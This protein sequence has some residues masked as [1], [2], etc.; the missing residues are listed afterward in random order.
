MIYLFYLIGFLFAIFVGD[1]FVKHIVDELWSDIGAVNAPRDPIRPNPFHPRMVGF[2]ERTLYVI[3]I[4]INSPQFIGVWLAVK[5][6]G[7][8]KRWNGNSP[9]KDP[10]IFTTA[11]FSPPFQ[12]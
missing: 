8:W 5:V 7:Q 2:I 9:P 10:T 3:S 1:F 11:R 12:Q 6:A 4:Q